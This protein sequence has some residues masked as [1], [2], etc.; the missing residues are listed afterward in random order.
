MNDMTAARS[1]GSTNWPLGLLMSE[2]TCG[3]ISGSGSLKLGRRGSKPGE[4]VG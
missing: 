2:H 3:E 4:R 1:F